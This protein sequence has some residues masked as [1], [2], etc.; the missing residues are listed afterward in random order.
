MIKIQI[1]MN[2]HQLPTRG[3]K[4]WGLIGCFGVLHRIKFGVIG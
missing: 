3:I 1:D 4:Y 2:K